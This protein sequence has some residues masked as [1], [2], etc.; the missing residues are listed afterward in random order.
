[1][2]VQELIDI[3]SEY[4]SDY[5]VMLGYTRVSDVYCEED[6]Y[7]ADSPNPQRAIGPA[8]IIE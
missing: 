1:M 3:L 6:F 2:T 5:P 8:I 4:P 7:F